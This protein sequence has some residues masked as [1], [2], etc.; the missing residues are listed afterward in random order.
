MIKFEFQIESHW[1]ISL[2]YNTQYLSIGSVNTLRPRQNHR[3]FVDDT[4]KPI[5]F[6][7]NIRISIKISLKFVPMC[8]INNIPALV[9]IMACCRS[10][11]KPLSE[12]M[13]V[14][15]LTHI[16]VTWPQWVNGFAPYKGSVIIWTKM[17]YSCVARPRCV[18]IDCCCICHM[19]TLIW[20][21]CHSV[22]DEWNG[23]SGWYH[24]DQEIVFAHWIS[25]KNLITSPYVKLP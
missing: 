5:F 21:S 9:Q 4:F 7:E 12:P 25:S 11:D 8:T 20:H 1:N 14:R 15:L 19:C 3:H 6:N 22:S 23:V 17:G 13:M 10:G 16:C 24:Q 2:G 18:N